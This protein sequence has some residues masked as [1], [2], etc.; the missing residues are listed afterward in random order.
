MKLRYIQNPILGNVQ[1]EFRQ[2]SV[3]IQ[4]NLD[5]GKIQTIQTQKYLD[6]LDGVRNISKFLK[7]ST[8]EFADDGHE[9]TQQ[10][11]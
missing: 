6:N 7:F 4:M 10:I 5:I 1:T 2:N 9:R 11:E 8:A 3:N